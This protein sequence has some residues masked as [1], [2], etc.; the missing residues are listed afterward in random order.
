MLC[1][2]DYLFLSF[3]AS[4]ELYTISGKE[5]TAMATDMDGTDAFHALNPGK[6]RGRRR[7]EAIQMPAELEAALKSLPTG[8]KLGYSPDGNPKLVR[9]RTRR[10]AK[11]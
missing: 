8:Y 10:K 11:G 1:N 6:R 7:R 4:S 2:G 9:V 5:L 3:S